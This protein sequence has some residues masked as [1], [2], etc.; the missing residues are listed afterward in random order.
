M[1]RQ[2]LTVLIITYNEESNLQECL[3]SV[4]WADEILVVDSF[5]T[6]STPAIAKAGNARVL[7]HE[8]VNDA[9]Q[10]N[11]AIPQAAFPWILVVDADERV[12]PELQQE[13][14]GL[15]T[16]APQTDGYYI[17]RRNFFFHHELKYGGVN[18][19]KLVRLF[20]RDHCRYENYQ[21]H[22]GVLMQGTPGVLQGRLLHYS[23][24]SYEQFFEKFLRYTTLAAKDLHAQKSKA[25]V[26]NLLFRPIFCFI[27]MYIIQRGFLDG[28]AGFIYAAFSAFYIFTKYAKLWQLYDSDNR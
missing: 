19:D 3:D 18:R 20:H 21:V 6:D 24:R 13:I 14:Q 27:K 25:G 9:V 7:Q 8:F 10:K 16:N 23:I 2:K 4:K 11:W 12:T 28:K 22:A 15:L 5:S 1:T 17:Y 26:I